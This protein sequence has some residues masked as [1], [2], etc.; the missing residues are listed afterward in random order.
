MNMPTMG[1]SGRPDPRWALLLTSLTEVDVGARPD[2][3][4][5]AASSWY[6]TDLA[7]VR[8]ADELVALIRVDFSVPGPM[9]DL[10]AVLSRLSDIDWAPN[11]AGYLWQVRGLPALWANNHRLFTQMVGV[12][13]HLCDRGRSTLVYV[14]FEFCRR[15]GMSWICPR[16]MPK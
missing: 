4:E 5:A 12:W 11:P 13:I 9:G 16:A 8:T 14:N 15:P 1:E 3:P 6:V 2:L 10:D 7:N